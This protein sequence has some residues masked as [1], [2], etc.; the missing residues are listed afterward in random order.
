MILKTILFT[1]CATFFVSPTWA[2]K[3]VSDTYLQARIISPYEGLSNQV[4]QKL[5]IEIQLAPGWYTYWRSPGDI[6]LPPKL[7]LFESK[8]VD[9]FKLL[10]PKP[11]RHEFAGFQN[12][13]YKQDIILPFEL[14]I[15][16]LNKPAHLLLN[17]SFMV[18]SDICIP[19]ELKL[20]LKLNIQ[21][22][23]ETE[24]A[25]LIKKAFDALPQNTMKGIEI[26]KSFIE[27]NELKIDLSNK[28]SQSVKDVFLD[29]GSI[30]ISSDKPK[31]NDSNTQII[32]D[33]LDEDNISN[34]HEASGYILIVFE[35]NTALGTEITIE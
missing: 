32:F 7:S 4:T 25:P 33:D 15:K 5:G 24:K 8:N 21:D 34:A 27:G 14:S 13:V 17:A 28:E 22:L 10:Y 1:L 19:Q 35:N 16:D 11:E 20:P 6:G 2:Q 18:C 26:T 31:I 23:T 29:F 30:F 3:W 12:Y 9:N